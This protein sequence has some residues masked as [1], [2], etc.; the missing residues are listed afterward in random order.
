[1]SE[2]LAP[3][4]ETERIEMLDLLRGVGVLGILLMNIYAFSMPGGAYFD[5]TVY[6]GTNVS[7]YAVWIFTHLFAEAKFYSLFSLLFGAGI[8]L[9]TRRL[10]EREISPRG[11]YYRRMLSLLL[12]GGLHAVFFWE[13]DILWTY[14]WCGILLYPLRRKAARTLAVIGAAGI[15][16]SIAG[17]FGLGS[18]LSLGRSLDESVRPAA[19]TAEAGAGA[20]TSSTAGT[21]SASEALRE[22]WREFRTE[23]DPTDR[24][25]AE[26]VETY[27]SGYGAIFA[28]RMKS[29]P[30]TVAGG[31]FFFPFAVGGIMLIGMAAMKSAILTGDRSTAFYGRLA[32]AGY[33]VGIPLGVIGTA[34]LFTREFD[35]PYRFTKDAGLHALATAGMVAGHVGTIVW[36]QKR[37]LLP[38][39]RARLRSVGRM[40]FTNYAMQ[41]LVCTILFYGYG[42]GLYGRL[43]RPAQMLVVLAVWVAQLLWSPF[44][45]RRFHYGPMEW[46]WRAMTYGARPRMRRLR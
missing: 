1:M 37:G 14:A 35:L 38:G 29:L 3:S 23:F 13:G 19:I 2:P 43:D 36:I 28:D 42:L 9:F 20:D 6:G 8:V 25:I 17:I 15:A 39:I 45:M 27:R 16:V 34:L 41:T 22:I 7:A 18:L 30:Q 5:P 11:P 31:M 32:G 12:F 46:L 10:E 26:K 21:D 33:A 4:P 24:E 44:W 40:A